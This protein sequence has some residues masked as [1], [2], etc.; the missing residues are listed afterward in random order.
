[1]YLNEGDAVYSNWHSSYIPRDDSVYSEDESDYFHNDVVGDIVICCPHCDNYILKDNANYSDYGDSYYC[2]EHSHYS[3]YSGDWFCITEVE[4]YKGEW[5]LRDEFQYS[6]YYNKDI[7]EHL[8]VFVD[9]LN[10]YVLKEEEEDILEGLKNG[11]IDKV[12]PLK[13]IKTIEPPTYV[14]TREHIWNISKIGSILDE[15]IDSHL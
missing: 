3:E 8:L 9:D 1:M 5:Y 6:Q 2:K 4:V 11:T 10:S 7:P 13:T 14:T 15:I 12:T